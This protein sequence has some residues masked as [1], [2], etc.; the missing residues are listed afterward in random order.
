MTQIELKAGDRVAFARAWLR[1]TGQFTGWAPFARG[2]VESVQ[3]WRD[4][5]VPPVVSVAW[6]D[7]SESRALAC[8]FGPG[9]PHPV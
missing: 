5:Q 9:R 8:K 7:G 6:D 2:R 3:A 1:S 4:A